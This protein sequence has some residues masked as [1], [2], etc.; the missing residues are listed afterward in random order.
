MEHYNDS[1]SLLSPVVL[2]VLLLHSLLTKDTNRSISLNMRGFSIW[3]LASSRSPSWSER[4]ETK[5]RQYQS[6]RLGETS[7]G[8]TPDGK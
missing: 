6:K 8:F 2:L 5:E 1:D 4:L 7:R 3:A